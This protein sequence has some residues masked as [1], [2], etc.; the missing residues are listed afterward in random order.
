LLR[1][2]PLWL[3]AH[4]DFCHRIQEVISRAATLRFAPERAF[5][6]QRAEGKEWSRSAKLRAALEM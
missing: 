5:G 3:L 4:V 2:Q 1:L 6:V